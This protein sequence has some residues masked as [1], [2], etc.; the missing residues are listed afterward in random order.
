MQGDNKSLWCQCST[1]N[2]QKLECACVCMALCVLMW[3]VHA[4]CGW[5]KNCPMQQ[6]RPYGAEKQ[7]P[8][9][10]EQLARGTNKQTPPFSQ[11]PSS[12]LH[13]YYHTQPSTPQA[14]RHKPTT[15]SVTPLFHMTYRPTY[16]NPHFM[17]VEDCT[18]LQWKTQRAFQRY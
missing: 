11:H 2:L 3:L 12:L 8:A 7:P 5:K 10:H 1:S 18:A 13:C 15:C 9:S 17:D 14:L 4:A 16:G 6:K